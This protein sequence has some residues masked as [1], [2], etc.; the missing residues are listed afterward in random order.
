MDPQ[1]PIDD[2]HEI[3]F[4]ALRKEATEEVFH[5][6]IFREVNEVIDVDA[7]RKRVLRFKL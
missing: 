3:H 7:E 5:C 2:P 1:E 4:A 6:G